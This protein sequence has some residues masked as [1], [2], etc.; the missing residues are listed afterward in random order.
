MFDA[1]FDVGFE[2]DC[3][4]LDDEDFGLAKSFTKAPYGLIAPGMNLKQAE[5][6]DVEK[7]CENIA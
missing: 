7:A 5:E 6:P 4:Y 3:S 2:M 1:D